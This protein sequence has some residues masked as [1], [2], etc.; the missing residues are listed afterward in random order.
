MNC[1]KWCWLDGLLSDMVTGEKMVL[2][3]GL[4]RGAMH[5]EEVM[6]VVMLV[7]AVGVLTLCGIWRKGLC[8]RLLTVCRFV[9]T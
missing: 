4:Q 8:I 9:C 2:E 6:T 7:V 5:E 3:E 1:T